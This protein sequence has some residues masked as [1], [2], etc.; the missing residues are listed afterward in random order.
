MT[1][2]EIAELFRSFQLEERTLDCGKDVHVI[3]ERFAVRVVQAERAKWSS[4]LREV[5]G[6]MKIYRE[7][8]VKQGWL[9]E[10]PLFSTREIIDR[11]E[12]LLREAE[13]GR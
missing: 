12:A 6:K 7:A 2:R 5:L 9:Q 13:E 3:A 10:E 8:L 1:T 11:A 4:Y